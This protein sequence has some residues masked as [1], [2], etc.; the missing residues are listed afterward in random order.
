MCI[1]TRRPCCLFDTQICTQVML[2]H[3]TCSCRAYTSSSL[4]GLKELAKSAPLMSLQHKGS[5][6]D[7]TLNA[8]HPK[9]LSLLAMEKD[10][11]RIPTPQRRIPRY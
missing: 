7:Q 3:C 10:F 6:W 5:R 1:K 11:K 9:S 2:E 4:E 8:L